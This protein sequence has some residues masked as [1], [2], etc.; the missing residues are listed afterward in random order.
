VAVQ[1]RLSDQKAITPFEAMS[2]A[3][4]SIRWV[5][6]N[7][8]KLGVHPKRIVAFGWSAGGHLAASTAIFLDSTAGSVSHVPDALILLSPALHLE[9]DRWVQQLLGKRANASSISPASHIRKGLPPTLILQGSDDTVTPLVGAE[10][11]CDRMKRAGNR[12]DLQ[13][14][15]GVGHLF[16]PKS[17]RDDGW[18]QPDPGVQAM[19]LQRAD[20]F[21][22]SL[23]FLK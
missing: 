7:A 18:P 1:Y 23:G 22:I 2:D 13:I 12:C 4:A 3:R 6:L 5:R 21:L 19:A 9:T 15:E 10:L 14:Y 17:V 16:T 8:V 20:E 11:F